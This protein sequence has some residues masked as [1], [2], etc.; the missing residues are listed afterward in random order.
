MKLFF[1]LVVSLFIT[2]FYFNLPCVAQTG[3]TSEKRGS[4]SEKPLRH[5]VLFRFKDSSTPEQVKKV[6][7]AFSA[8]PG[9][10]NTITGYE[11]GTNIST[12][13]LAQ[14]FTH[15][16]MVSFKNEAGRDFYLPHPAHQEF[17]K[18]LSP[19]LDKVLVFDF[20]GQP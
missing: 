20:T 8:L 13:N 15:C 3:T 2:I 7:D 4:T 12:E 1:S 17:V 5:I 14:G 9:K 16:F 10:I 19:H 6:V 18:I 11:W